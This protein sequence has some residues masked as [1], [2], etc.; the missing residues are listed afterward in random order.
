MTT[1]TTT[2]SS[3]QCYATPSPFEEKIGYYRAVRHGLQIFVSG[4]TA[5]DPTSSH[6]APQVLYPGDAGQ[7]ARVALDECIRAV[8]ALGGQGAESVVRVRMF[9]SHP[10][11]CMAVGEAFSE[12]LGRAS[13]PGIGAAATMLVVRD[14]FV[15]DQPVVND[16]DPPEDSLSTAAPGEGE[17]ERNESV[18][19]YDMHA[20][21]PNRRPVG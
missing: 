4:T 13:R 8:Q 3:K 20:S 14:G 10:D 17:G 16:D 21:R 6:A 5:V 18:L 11:D 12:L 19:V 2:P 15:D 7:Q 9:V 1:T